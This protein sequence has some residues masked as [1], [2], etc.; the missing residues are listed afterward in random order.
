[1]R[2][3]GPYSA[4]NALAVDAIAEI[5]ML[6]AARR[7]QAL[8]ISAT[9]TQLEGPEVGFSFLG[10]LRKRMGSTGV[11]V[12]ADF[13]MHVRDRW[14]GPVDRNFPIRPPRITLIAF[15]GL[16]NSREVA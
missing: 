4:T 13:I 11:T 12:A 14:S 3:G 7:E 15:R 5:L 2:Y 9:P 6:V 10:A 8:R 16:S 1:M